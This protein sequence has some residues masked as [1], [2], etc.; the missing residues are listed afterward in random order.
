V[1]LGEVGAQLY[2]SSCTTCHGGAGAGSAASPSLASIGGRRTRKEVEETIRSGRGSMPAFASLS[3]L[4]RRA[5]SAFLLDEGGDEKLPPGETEPSFGGE[6]PWVATGHNEFRDP[7]GFPANKRPWGTLS[8]IDLAK[9]EIRWQVPLGTYPALA[10]RG[11]P[12]TGTFNI[13]G[14]LVTAGGLVF[15]GAA[16]DERFHAYDAATGALLWEHGLDAGGYASPATF[17][18][19]GRQYVVIAAGGGGKPETRPGDA[20]YCFA[21]PRAAGGMGKQVSEALRPASTRGSGTRP[22]GDGQCRSKP[23]SP[24]TCSV[25]TCP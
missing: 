22:S 21:L 12:A 18:V 19:D 5:L 3:D 7:E 4:E 11:L 1:T 13:G 9:G 10:A 24:N 20:Y 2:Q 15:I 17:E 25:V 16:M 8:A 23:R 6:I 14:P